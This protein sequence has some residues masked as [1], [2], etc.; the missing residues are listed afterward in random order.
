MRNIVFLHPDLGIG[1]AER[2]VVDAAIGLQ[3][4]GHSVTIFTSHCDPKHC[5]DEARDGGFG[6]LTLGRVTLNPSGRTTRCARPGEFGIPPKYRRALLHPLR[7]SAPTPPGAASHTFWRAR[8]TQAR[9]VLCRPALCVHSF[10]KAL[11]SANAHT[12]LL[13]LPG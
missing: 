7:H 11:Q 9:C 2:L 4:L 8:R 12:F 3:T 10:A 6:E 5:F 13:P 1:G